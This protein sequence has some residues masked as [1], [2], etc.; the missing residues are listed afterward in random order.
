MS[1]TG[2]S[3]TLEVSINPISCIWPHYSRYSSRSSQRARAHTQSFRVLLASPSQA[4]SE[5]IHSRT[6]SNMCKP[7][8]YPNTITR[9]FN[10]GICWDRE[11]PTG[12]L[13]VSTGSQIRLWLSNGSSFRPLQPNSKLSSTGSVVF[14]ETSRS[15]S[16]DL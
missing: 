7:W 14:Y 12:Y 16:M 11:H 3:T 9:R 6:Y 15:C 1:A 13:D 8:V 5:S 2:S 10:G 4:T